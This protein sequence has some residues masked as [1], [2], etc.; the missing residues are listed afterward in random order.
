MAGFL[1]GLLTLVVG[2]LFYG[3]L[4]E[5]TVMPDPARRTPA[6]EHADGV[7]F[8]VLPTWRVFL[9]QLLNIAG[10]G[11]VFGAILGALWGPQVLLWIVLGAIFGGAVHDFLSGAMSMRQGGAG[12]PELVGRHLGRWPRHFGT[13]FVLILVILVGTVF[14]KGPAL[15]ILQLLP[16]AEIDGLLGG[17]GLLTI[18]W[19]GQPLWLWIVMGAIFSYYVAATVLPV[20]KLIGRLYPLF[21]IAL[22]VMVA[23]LTLTLLSGGIHAPSFTLD[24]L[25]P[26]RAP[27]WPVIF[28]TVSCGAISGFHATQSPMMARCLR[29]ESHM[30]PVFYGAMIA[31]GII[32]LVWATAAHGHYGSTGA[33]AGALA[34][35]GPGQVVH[36][37]CVSSMGVFGGLLAV[38]GVVV[39]PIT[40]GDTAFRVARLILAEYLHLPQGHAR[41]RYQIAVPLFAL[42]MV[43][44]L[45][46]F[47]LI[48]RYFGWA[49]QTLAAVALWTGAAFLRRRPTALQWLA[50]GPAVF[51][52]VVTTAYILSEPFAFGLSVGVATTAAV[53]L[54]SCLLAVFLVLVRPSAT[55]GAPPPRPVPTE[56]ERHLGDI[57]S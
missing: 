8:V 3:R 48:W 30:R 11:P 4:V 28:I 16:A 12:F 42:S 1:I 31:E 24:S 23:G 22:L 10:L 6:I 53:V 2:Y 36:Q 13:A 20:D 26:Q 32:A 9:I 46:D 14:V 56:I 35:G 54:A 39:L 5:R 50:T 57:A 25:H 55:A 44:C 43:L 18:P 37:V 29:S 49:N 17:S 40:S 52:T 19:R 15:L 33:L 34:A 21:A 41:Q 51:M 47:A 7:D 45:V 27:A 38:L